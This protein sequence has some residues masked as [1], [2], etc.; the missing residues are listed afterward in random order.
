VDASRCVACFNCISNCDEGGI[1]LNWLGKAKAKGKLKLPER[2]KPAA[3]PGGA[4][5]VGGGGAVPVPVHVPAPVPAQQPVFTRRAF[6]AGVGSVA[7]A[8]GA[9]WLGAKLSASPDDPK[10]RVVAP[11]GALSRVR[12]VGQCT[13]C[14]LCVSACPSH[15][16]EPAL[17]QYGSF[18]GFMKPRMNYDRSFCNIDCVRCGEVCPDGAL[19]RLV[20][21]DK[22]KTRIGLAKVTLERCVVHRENT[23]CGACGEHCPTAALQMITPKGG[24]FPEPV[25]NETQCIGCGACEYICP[26]RPEKAVV[27]HGLAVHETAS[28][29]K[30]EAVKAPTPVDDFAF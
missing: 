4:S 15:V 17:A 28:E 18:S 27:I 2:K 30:E 1:H 8:G 25:V 3:S 21:A 9:G 23:A 10:N 16:L 7:V 22:P 26:A 24:K 13:G 6:V 19:Q 20:P 12:F 29:L 14:L 5:G 11:P